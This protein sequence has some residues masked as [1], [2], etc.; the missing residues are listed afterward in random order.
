MV[1]QGRFQKAFSMIELIAVVLLLAILAVFAFSRLG[2]LGSFEQKAF[3]DEFTSALRYAQKLALSTGCN[4][5][6][7]ITGSS[8]AL[9]QGSTCTSNSFNRNVLHPAHR[10]QAYQNLSFPSGVT[11]SPA[12]SMQFTPQQ[13][14]N[15]LTGNTTFTVAGYSLTVYQ[16]SGL[17][18]VN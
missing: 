3:F 4:V 8:Y 13:Q 7:S 18:D 6:V 9:R 1:M 17:V 15:G 12:A 10:N 2:N 5:Q 16:Q 11:I 14:V